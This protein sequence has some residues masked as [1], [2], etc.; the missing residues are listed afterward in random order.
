[1]YWTTGYEASARD[2]ALSVLATTAPPTRTVTREPVGRMAIGWV[3]SGIFTVRVI[4]TPYGR[5][6]SVP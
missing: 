2:S 4:G 3:A 6:L 1:M 5:P